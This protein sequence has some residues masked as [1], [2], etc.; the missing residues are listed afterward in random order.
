[1]MGELFL[2]LDDFYN[3]FDMTPLS[4][5][6]FKSK[7]NSYINNEPF[8]EAFIDK[9]PETDIRRIECE[10]LLKIYYDI[11][12]KDKKIFLKEYYDQH[13]NINIDTDLSSM[14]W[15]DEIKVNELDIFNNG[16]V[17]GQI[18]K[19]NNTR[20]IKNINFKDMYST[21]KLIKKDHKNS[22]FLLKNF[23]DNITIHHD[24]FTPATIQD[25]KDCI[26]NQ[27]KEMDHVNCRDII[28][29]QQPAAT[30]T[31]FLS[32]KE[33]V[34]IIDMEINKKRRKIFFTGLRLMGHKASTFNPYTAYYIFSRILKSKNIFT[35]T[36]G[37]NSYLVGALNCNNVKEYVGVDVIKS[38]VD[39]SSLIVS[40]FKNHQKT[41]IKTKFYCCPSEMLDKHYKFSKVY[42]K[43]FDTVFCS[44]PYFNLELYDENNINQ[45]TNKFPDYEKWLQGYWEETIKICN[46][47]MIDGARFA[48]VVSNFKQSPR[49]SED[50]CDIAKKYFTLEKH[51]NISWGGFTKV[52]GKMEHGNNEDL[53]ILKK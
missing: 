35:P 37:W 15:G 22:F 23:I 2:S 51:L 32:A 45:S 19:G 33:T 4:F 16:V 43:H 11:I 42:E 12:W 47:V 3:L 27:H 9:L 38:V 20:L 31:K 46:K 29:N 13:L 10:S 48:F 17:N 41:D 39:K 18:K 6:D 28:E 8:V 34:D 49:L 50:M 40:K 52:V 30:L 36:L 24:F 21:S 7:I 1:M 14:I 5:K 44:P 53:W 26:Y 25:M